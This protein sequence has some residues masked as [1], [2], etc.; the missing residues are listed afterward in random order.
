MPNRWNE[1]TT[2]KCIQLY[3]KNENLWNMYISE[4]KNLDTRSASMQSI[5][6]ELNI[7]N[8]T[9]KDVPFIIKLLYLFVKCFFIS[10]IIVIIKILCKIY[11]IYILKF[12]TNKSKQ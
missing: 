8:F 12:L 7:P 9:M 3:R 1:E 6:S 10:V 2:L 5:A 4:Y 11:Y